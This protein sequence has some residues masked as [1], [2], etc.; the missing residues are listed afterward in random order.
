MRQKNVKGINKKRGF[1]NMK[2]NKKG[3][4]HRI[5][6]SPMWGLGKV[7]VKILA[8]KYLKRLFSRLEP[9][10]WVTNEQTYHCANL[11]DS[12]RQKKIKERN[13]KC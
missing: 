11:I 12:L 9:R 5:R 13:R 8:F 1:I 2:E 4:T 10:S 6:L 7:N 3:W